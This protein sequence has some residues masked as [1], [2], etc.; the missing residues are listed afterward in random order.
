MNRVHININNIIFNINNI[1]VCYTE[2]PQVITVVLIFSTTEQ[3][4]VSVI[5]LLYVNKKLIS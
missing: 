3:L 4:W 1:Q 2:Y 5:L